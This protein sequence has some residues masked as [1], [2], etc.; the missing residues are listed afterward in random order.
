MSGVGRRVASPR[1]FEESATVDPRTAGADS[2]PDPLRTVDARPASVDP[3]AATSGQNESPSEAGEAVITDDDLRAP[4]MAA[5]AEGRTSD[6][7]AAI[8]ELARRELL[9]GMKPGLTVHGFRSSFRDWCGEQTNYPREV[10]E[11][12]LAHVLSDGTEAAYRRGDALEK[13]S[14]LMESWAGYCGST[15]KAEGKVIPIRAAG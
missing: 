12:A 8:S 1:G 3:I 5:L 2:A 13:R 7:Q 15:P 14:R 6:A 4:V 11:A 10:A 9:R